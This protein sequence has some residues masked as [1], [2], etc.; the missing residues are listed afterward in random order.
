[1]RALARLLALPQLK[2]PRTAFLAPNSMFGIASAIAAAR[3]SA[4]LLP[5]AVDLETEPEP[6]AAPGVN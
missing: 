4:G 3:T 2:L 5:P 1:M 6:N